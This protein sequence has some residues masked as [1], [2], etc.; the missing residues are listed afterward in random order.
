MKEDILQ[1][2]WKYQLWTTLNLQT[3][4]NENIEVINP[5][6]FNKGEGPDFLHSKIKIGEK[7]WHGSVE[8]HVNSKNWHDHKH[9]NNIHYKNVILHVVYEKPTTEDLDFPFETL[10]VK[11]FLNL[12][13]LEKIPYLI[14]SNKKIPCQ[15]II[16]KFDENI[17]SLHRDRLY[18]DKVEAKWNAINPEN[19]SNKFDFIYYKYLAYSF[20]LIQNKQAFVQII[21]NIGATTLSKLII[22]GEIYLFSY[23][24]G[25]IGFFENKISAETEVL[26]ENWEYLKQLYNYKKPSVNL[27]FGK[28]RPPNNPILRLRQ[29]AKFISNEKIDFTIEDEKAL[30]IN[31]QK[32][33]SQF[34]LHKSEIEPFIKYNIEKEKISFSESFIRILMVNVY[35]PYRFWYNNLVQFPEN[36]EY[37]MEQLYEL[38]PETNNVLKIFEKKNKN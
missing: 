8:I 11:P 17:W 32:K 23:I 16:E 3:C 20:G 28:I 19:S 34:S 36:N 5:G 15:D 22:K 2:Y 37:L 26:K 7:I 27:K 1:F 9:D 29:F 14:E 24:L 31:F 13:V 21:E 35:F 38:K 12:S 33:L 4:S 6:S 10:W 25:I 18:I 30:Y